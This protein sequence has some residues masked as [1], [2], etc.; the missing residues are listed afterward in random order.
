MNA[1][2]TERRTILGKACGWLLGA[3]GAAALGACGGG[4]S[5]SGTNGGNPTSDAY[6]LGGVVKL[7]VVDPLPNGLPSGLSLGNGTETLSIPAGATTFEFATSLANGTAYTVSVKASP[8]GL[9]CTASD[10]T[11]TIAGA[12]VSNVV[13]SCSDASYSVGGTISGLSASGL[14]LTNNGTDA[15]PLASGATSFTFTTDIAYGGAYAVTVQTQ[16][17]G[18]TCSVAHG[19]ATMGAAAVNNVTVTC[20]ATAF[21][22]GGSISGLS[23]SGL[24]LANG[25]ETVAVAAGAT[26]F[27]FPNPIASGGLYSVTVKTQPSGQ[28]C[29][30]ANATGTMAPGGVT[31]V[32]VTC[33]A[34]GFSIGGTI[35]GLSA[36]GLVLANGTDT[37][38]PPVAA[39]SFTMPTPVAPGGAY[40]VVVQ[41]QP[42]GLTCTVA[43][44][45]G[46][47]NAAVGN[48]A[49]TC[50]PASGVNGTIAG[51]HT[52]GLVLANGATAQA[53]SCANCRLAPIGS[54]ATVPAV[55]T[56]TL[57]LNPTTHLV[58]APDSGGNTIVAM[59]PVKRTTT[60]ISTGQPAGTGI[61]S[62]G[63]DPTSNRLYA[64]NKDGVLSA[65][66][67]TTNGVVGTAQLSGC[68]PGA[69]VVNPTTHRVYI[70]VAENCI[71]AESS[72]A[73]IWV[74]DGASL[75]V[76]TASTGGQPLA[77]AVNTV[78]NQVYVSDFASGNVAVID[79]ASNQTTLVPVGPGPGAIAVNESTNK[80]YV[81][82]SGGS[83]QVG[84]SFN[85]GNSVVVIDGASNG[86]TSVTTVYG[87]GAM[88]INTATNK[89][90]VGSVFPPPDNSNSVTV[91]D[92]ATN[93]T[94]NIPNAGGSYV[95]LDAQNNLVFF[96]YSSAPDYYTFSGV[97]NVING[98]TNK[99]LA[100]G[101][102]SYTVGPV[103][104]D[105]NFNAIYLANYSTTYL[106]NYTGPSVTNA[107]RI[108][109][110]SV[111]LA[112]LAP[113]PAAVPFFIPAV[114]G[115]AYNISVKTQ[116]SGQ[117]C[118]ISSGT[119]TV[120]SSPAGGVA[121]QCVDNFQPVMGSLSDTSTTWA[122]LS[123][124]T[125][126]FAVAG[127]GAAFLFSIP[128]PLGDSYTLTAGHLGANCTSTNASGTVG[129]PVVVTFTCQ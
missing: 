116:P 83:R 69:M 97:A 17:T 101:D 81:C 49:V 48:I 43:G 112:A 53:A 115:S 27:T 26:S 51:L 79:G 15:L 107:V 93:Q 56:S 58:Y 82:M 109:D 37:L 35:S 76:T 84:P 23:A 106:S 47:A 127:A 31:N 126:S 110:E 41:T 62:I 59:D 5:G 95:S 123:D 18:Q 10:N 71:A 63:L 52:T 122:N 25:A 8:S 45:S 60:S 14:V 16:P 46:T 98:A 24:V 64:A 86:T 42:A 54:D 38:S 99:A 87:P 75:Q 96:S 39:T 108:F 13:V 113:A 50:T 72:P 104:V 111:L 7:N 67:L 19:A 9:V 118:T 100:M 40:H 92:G 105:P 119:G 4:G 12:S 80:V 103:L 65:I 74:V 114:A 73:S 124:G 129:G 30:V 89:I 70:A 34:S 78:T 55:D 85:V 61:A 68:T 2:R 91:I 28:T 90:Y 102:A 44:G 57:L 1:N 29:S 21:S 120:G 3:L 6:K 128:A 36:A 121:V 22:L 125:E 32:A 117:T 20:S 88:A 11:G 77:L 66:D 33:H 94:I